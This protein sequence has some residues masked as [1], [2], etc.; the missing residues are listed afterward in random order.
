MSAVARLNSGEFS[1]KR[2]ET[3]FSAEQPLVLECGR[4]LG[5]VTV[6]Y[7]TFGQLSANRDNVVLVCHALTGDSHV[8][9]RYS[10]DDPR[11]GWWDEAVGPGKVVDTNRYFVLCANVLGG[12]QGTTGPASVNP[13]TGQPWGT[14]F[15]LVTVRDMVRVQAALLDR[16]GIARVVAAMGG[17]LG[18]MQAI[19]WAVTYPDRIL[20]VIPMAGA[21]HFHPQGIAYNEVQR[22]AI[23]TDPEF[24]GGHYYPGPG[25]VRGL[26]TARMLGMITYRSDESMWQQFDRRVRPAHLI[27]RKA[28]DWDEGYGSRPT[29][30]GGPG[31]EGIPVPAGGPGERDLDRGFG[32][33]YEVESYL[34]Y[35][36]QAL[37]RRFD[38][39]S[40]LYLS[41]AMD[42][43]DISRGYASMAAAYAR[44]KAEA[45]VIGI[46][47]DIL[48]PPYL[49]QE[50]AAGITAAGGQ[51]TYLEMDSPWGHDAFLVDFP[52]VA[53]AVSEFLER[54]QRRLQAG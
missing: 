37:V 50:M 12:C 39:N 28:E 43:H 45:L 3:L 49:Q 2:Y 52:L 4:S 27:G 51:A 19:E 36:G 11:P 25:P 41:K 40:Y 6:A 24:R 7:E 18:A 9:G 22:Q 47:S 38:A 42:L 29:T 30:V 23:Q 1:Q 10:A 32:I 15:P 48:F 34:H 46:R 16:L 31:A 13:A 44:I 14:D 33:A 20:G 26:A 21:G 53:G 54:N 5:P 35:N 8:C 17:S